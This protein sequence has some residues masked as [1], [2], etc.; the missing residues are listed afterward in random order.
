MV[1]PPEYEPGQEATIEIDWAGDVGV[2]VVDGEVVMDSFWDGSVWELDASDF[3]VGRSFELRIV[4]LRPDAAVWVPEAA[5]QLRRAT[6]GS[7]AEVRRVCVRGHSQWA[8][9]PNH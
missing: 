8:E 6:A 9:M 5:E 2:V 3:H 1:L 7:L 4:P